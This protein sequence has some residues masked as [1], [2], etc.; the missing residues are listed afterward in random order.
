MCIRDSNYHGLG[1]HLSTYA[2]SA[3]LYEVGFNHFFRGKDEGAAGDQIFYQGHGAPGIYSR[4]YL[5]GRLAEAQ[6]DRF[7]REVGGQGLS[8]YPHPRLMPEFWEFPT[9]LLYTSP[10]PRDRQK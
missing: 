10:S 7:R 2:S 1:G 5:E 3:S 8:S 9:C 4:A 6:L